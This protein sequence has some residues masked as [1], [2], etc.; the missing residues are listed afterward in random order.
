MPCEIYAYSDASWAALL[1]WNKWDGRG[2]SLQFPLNVS[3]SVVVSRRGGLGGS[4]GVVVVV[5]GRGRL[6]TMMVGDSVL[7]WYSIQ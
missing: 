6:L 5:R 4:S 1:R 7:Y 3:L 2:D